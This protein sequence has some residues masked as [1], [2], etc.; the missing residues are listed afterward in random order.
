MPIIAYRPDSDNILIRNKMKPIHRQRGGI[1]Q[2]GLPLRDDQP[3]IFDI[4]SDDKPGFSVAAAAHAEPL[5][6]P[7]RI[8]KHPFVLPHRNAIRRDDFSLLHRNIL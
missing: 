4:L 6:L 7:D 8:I 5:A 3:V 1:K 2:V